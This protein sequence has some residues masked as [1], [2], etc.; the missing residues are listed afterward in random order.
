MSSCRQDGPDPEDTTAVL[1]VV[2]IET[3]TVATG[4]RSIQKTDATSVVKEDTTPAIV[5]GIVEAGEGN[6]F[7]RN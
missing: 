2:V 5:L 7:I 6:S 1:L 4:D 3:E